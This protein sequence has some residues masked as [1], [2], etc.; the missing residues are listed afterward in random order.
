MVP[1]SVDRVER[2]AVLEL[3]RDQAVLL[4]DLQRS[5]LTEDVAFDD[6]LGVDSLALIEF[7]MAVEDALGISLPEDEIA[8]TKRLG[9]FVDLATAKT[10]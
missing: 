7:A 4:L 3:V 6:D 10:V 2:A 8:Q 9:E 1:S 5:E